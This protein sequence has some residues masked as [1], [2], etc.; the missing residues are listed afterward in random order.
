MHNFTADQ[1]LTGQVAVM[2]LTI[3]GFK[4]LVNWRFS[5]S[6]R[7]QIRNQYNEITNL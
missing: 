1:I 7:N 2:K 5:I 3:L 4:V 6:D